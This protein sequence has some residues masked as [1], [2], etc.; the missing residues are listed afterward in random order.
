VRDFI[1]WLARRG[2]QD[3]RNLLELTQMVALITMLEEREGDGADAVHLSTL[4]A[5]K[6]L[7]YPHVFL[8]GLEEG[9]LPHREAIDAGAVDEERRL[10]YVG[11]TRAQQT[12]H[13]SY[14]R[15]RR[16]AGERVD[17]VPSRFLAELAQEDV[18]YADAPLPPDKA[19]QAKAEG[20]A[21]LRALKAM[22]G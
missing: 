19:A 18:R 6:G 10:M 16:R 9:I 7:E 11:L 12:L 5:A 22:L 4:H 2:E 20:S 13:L 3:G 21:R 14:C 17:C 15:T 8:V 1:A